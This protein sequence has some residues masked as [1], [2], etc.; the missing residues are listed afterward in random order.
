M[1]KM[2]PFKQRYH[3]GVIK[4]ARILMFVGGIT[5]N[6]V[7]F[8]QVDMGKRGLPKVMMLIKA[9]LCCYLTVSVPWSLVTSVKARSLK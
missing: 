6:N 7:V 5:A 8:L 9:K 4:K 1:L 3:R 2:L